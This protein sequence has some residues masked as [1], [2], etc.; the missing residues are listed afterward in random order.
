MAKRTVP[1]PFS[2]PEGNGL[3][4][5]EV[6]TKERSREPAIQLL[7]YDDGKRSLRFCFYTDAKYQRTPLILTE[8]E[9]EK[10]AK[11]IKKNPPI[12]GLLLK[13]SGK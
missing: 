7:E 1:R 9:I 10:L 2:L 8:E 3:V 6:F 5:E 12:L 11:E 13:L 4:A